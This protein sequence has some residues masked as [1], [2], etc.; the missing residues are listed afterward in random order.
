MP[1]LPTDLRNKLER[2]IIDARDRAEE[3]ARAALEAMAVHHHEPYPHQSPDERR[4]RNHLRAHAR[5][6][7]DGQGASG[8]LHI[9]HLAH[10]CA[11]EHWHRMV[12]A[13]FLAENDLLIEPTHGVPMSLAECKELADKEK[14]DLWLYA[15]RCAQQMLPQIFRPDD[16]LLQVALAREHRLKLETILS[17]LPPEVF[18]ADDSLGWVYQFWQSKKKDEV[19]SSGEKIT[20]DTLPA[21]TQLFTEHYMVLFLLHNTIGAWHAGKVLAANPKLA[22]NAKDEDELRRAVALKAAGGYSFDY[23][24][25]VRGTDGKGGP[26]RPAAGVFE[27]WPKKAAELKALDPCCGSGHFLVAIFEL[28]FRLRME[29]EK[30]SLAAT[31]DAVLKDNIF[32]LELDARC[33]QIAAFNLAISAWKHLG[34]TKLPALNIACSGLAVNAKKDAWLK[35]SSGDDKLSFP[36]GQMWEL[37]QQASV[38]GSLINPNLLPQVKIGDPITFAD[39]RPVIEKALTL[40]GKAEDDFTEMAVAAQGMARAAEILSDH[41]TF[42][43]T[44]VPYLGRGKQDTALKGYCDRIYPEAKADLATCFI[45]RCLDYVRKGGSVGLVVPWGW[46]FAANYQLFRENILQNVTINSLPKLGEGGFESSAA[47]GA[48][49]ILPI[50]SK[51][52]PSENNT[53][54]AIDAAE[55]DTLSEKE[56]MLRNGVHLWLNQKAQLENPDSRILFGDATK[57]P[58]LSRQANSSQGI[59]TGDDAFAKRFFWE[60]EA[61]QDNWKWMRSTVDATI[62]YGGC[63]YVLRWQGN[64]SHIARL[65]GQAAWGK[66]GIAVSLMREL[67]SSI[68]LGEIFDSNVAAVVIDDPKLLLPLWAYCSSSQFNAE[69]RKIDPEIKVETG[70]V[71]KIPFD[72]PHWQEVASRQYPKGIPA[73][74]SENP[75]QWLFSGH[76][77]D[78]TDPLHISVARLLGYRWPRQTGSTFPDCPTLNTDDLEKFADDDGIVCIPSVRGE[79]PAA[80][81]F[82]TLL[83]ACGIKPDRDLD[84]WLRDSFFEEHCKLFHHRPFIWH[85]WDG[86]S[87]DGFHALVNY[88]KLAEGNGK[89]RKLLESLTY[90]Y[91]G[92]WIN[93]QNDGVKNGEE[94]AEDRLAAATELKKRLEAIL[95]GEPPFDIFVR[96]KPIHQQ[97]IGWEPDINDGV[98]LNI[99]PFLVDDLPSG[100]TGAGILRWKPNIKWDKDRGK[101]P[102]RPKDEFP[103]F[104]DGNDFTGVRANDSHLTTEQKQKARLKNS[105]TK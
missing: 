35:I 67:R 25:F 86:R 75:T 6:L 8:R 30:L 33:T 98:R 88:H 70:S 105:I 80:D 72:L 20:G 95:K 15:S 87:R 59:K 17:G 41:F 47:A 89:G 103:W 24:R 99:R 97:P 9:S 66:K 2:A 92:E 39:L 5:Q 93:R 14:V 38:L 102:H 29:E 104:W 51:I 56:K 90:S 27:G 69:V 62:D 64:G 4:L 74:H 34:W 82:A 36:L 26:W 23:L 83:A 46:T 57:A 55:V 77:K 32:G 65:Q 76:P 21:V 48:F 63:E 13:R 12:F 78:S 42:V 61:N 3:G 71:T 52:S 60:F 53:F 58:L 28:L 44:N 73:P 45:S 19:N 37:F 40:E 81:R 22:E 18:K 1:A 85:I 84:K 96:W 50:L 10:E 79:N 94:G 7:G 101:E 31:V 54:F 68:Y 43:V 16:P 100:R 91:L 11:Y 49:V